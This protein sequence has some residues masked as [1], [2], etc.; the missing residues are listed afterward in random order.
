MVAGWYMI[1]VERG[2][3]PTVASI[4]LTASYETGSR[5]LVARAQARAAG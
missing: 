1:T 4:V 2:D 3:P 5:D